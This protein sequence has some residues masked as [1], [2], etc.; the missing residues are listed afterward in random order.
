MN[1]V[2]LKIYLHIDVG[3]M[4]YIIEQPVGKMVRVMALCVCSAA[5]EHESVVFGLLC[6]S[7]QILYLVQLQ[8]D[9]LSPVQH[10]KGVWEKVVSHQL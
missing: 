1:C 6:V 10:L 8:M 2:H 9:I 5:Y 7:A 4:N 3:I